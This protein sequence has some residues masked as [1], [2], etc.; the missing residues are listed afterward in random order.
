MIKYF[1]NFTEQ[2]MKFRLSYITMEITVIC[3]FMGQN[4][5]IQG[6]RF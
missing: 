2:G 5:S 3:L 4:V 1:I 6:K